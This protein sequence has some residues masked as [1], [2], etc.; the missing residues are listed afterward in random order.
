MSVVRAPLAEAADVVTAG[1]PLVVVATVD[2]V[3]VGSAL[4]SGPGAAPVVAVRR[5]DPLPPPVERAPTVT[6][7]VCSRDRPERLARCLASIAEAIAVAGDEA[8]AELL[9]VDNASADDRTAA[10]A[11]A[12]GARLVHEPVA[13]LDVA[14]ERA[15]ASCTTELLA[16]TD[17]DVVVDPAWLRT[18]VRAFGADP[19]VAAVT[20]GVLALALDTPARLDFERA[21][22][23]HLGWHARRVRLDEV[24]GPPFHP[25]IGVG[26]DMAFRVEAL[27]RIGPFDETLDTGPPLAGGGDLDVLIRAALDAGVRYEPSA[28]VFHEHRATWPELRA[29]YRSWG[30]SWG[31]LLHAWYRREPDLRPA[32][33]RAA[34]DALRFY[35]GDLVRG[36]GGGRRRR[37]HAIALLAGF[38]RGVTVAHPRSRRR[39]AARRRAASATARPTAPPAAPDGGD[40]G[41]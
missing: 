5:G 12:A 13:G 30:A 26:C 20:G 37:A 8:V 9:V 29:Q 21:G 27:R 39:M 36:P 11:R 38:A 16:L 3:P 41:P 19:E 24:P 14:R 18:L 15:V 25:A 22:G 10:V 1:A 23:F 34:I 28:L 6:V 2:D 7:A 40:A 17:D 35:L 31:A 32:A 33:R 4:V